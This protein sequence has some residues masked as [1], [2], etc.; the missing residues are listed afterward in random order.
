MY[1]IWVLDLVLQL[2]NCP[3]KRVD[4]G[5]L[6]LTARNDLAKRRLSSMVYKMME[7]EFCARW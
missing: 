2:T 6:A 7:E 4:L 3:G 1:L 5:D